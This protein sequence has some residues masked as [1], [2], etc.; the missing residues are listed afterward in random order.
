MFQ[1]RESL[2]HASTLI[3]SCYSQLA[4]KVFKKPR[5]HTLRPDGKKNEILEIKKNCYHAMLKRHIGQTPEFRLEVS[6][7]TCLHPFH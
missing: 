3:I 6:A 4:C 2:R 5:M 1:V 7:A